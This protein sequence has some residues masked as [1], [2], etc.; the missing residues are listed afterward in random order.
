[1]HF[2]LTNDDGFEAPGL[3][4]LRA[5]VERIEK[6]QVAET[7]TIAPSEHQSGCGHTTTTRRPLRFN[8]LG[9]RHLS[10]DGSP[11]DCVRLGLLHLADAVDW[12]LSGI[13]DG[14]NLG[15]DVVMSGTAA[16]AR[17]AALFGR[18]S[19]ALSHY[20]RRGQAID[21]EWAA[22]QAARVL[23]EL[24][25]K[26]PSPGAFWNVNFPA[27]EADPS[28][29]IVFCPLDI[30]PLHVAY[31]LIDDA[32]HFCGAYAQRARAPGSDV[33]LCFGGAITIS[34]VKLAS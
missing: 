4:A 27:A 14:G 1:M 30:Y 3:A 25:Q 13:N 16:A 17:E 34:E 26:P 18:P 33:E 19:I 12:V 2:L 29:E 11:A 32:Y 24:L 31:E 5:A 23:A 8:R 22:R 28:P 9:E 7:T 20:H 10:V 6:F 21:W 15:I